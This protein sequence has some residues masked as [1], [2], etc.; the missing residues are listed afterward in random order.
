VIRLEECLIRL[1][2][3]LKA[4]K[5][6][7]ALIGGMAVALRAIA[8]TTQD[9]DVAIAVRSEKEADNLV[10]SLHFR[11]YHDQPL[12]PMR[13]Q[14]DQD[15]LAMI[16]LLAP[17]EE[18]SRIAVDLFFDSSGVEEEIV[19]AAQTLRILPGVYVPVATTGHLIALKVL[20]GRD[21]DR[22]DVRSLL[23]RAD[24]RERERARET[25]VLIERRGFHRGKENL[26]A[27]LTRLMAPE[28]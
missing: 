13:W 4:L 10:R 21:K 24:L 8:R 26:L 11:G 1:D 14:T 23:A 12:D 17:G 15:R 5:I 19:A 16:R 3:D 7:W 22:A 2:A 27:D 6:R 20:A 9:V 28:G 18:P 25:L